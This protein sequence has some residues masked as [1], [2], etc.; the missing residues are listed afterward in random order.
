MK[1]DKHVL[2]KATHFELNSETRLNVNLCHHV[3]AIFRCFFVFCLHMLQS[4]S[5]LVYIPSVYYFRPGSKLCYTLRFLRNATLHLF[6]KYQKRAVIMVGELMFVFCRLN[7]HFNS[8]ESFCYNFSKI[9][10]YKFITLPY[11]RVY[12]LVFTDSNCYL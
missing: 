4:R 1:L 6:T 5:N 10:I 9:E 11:L 12:K 3:E 8:H 2:Q 7:I